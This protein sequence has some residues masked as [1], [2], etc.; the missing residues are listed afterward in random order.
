V[1]GVTT[2]PRVIRFPSANVSLPRSYQS[3]TLSYFPLFTHF[4]TLQN[5]RFSYGP[6]PDSWC[7]LGLVRLYVANFFSSPPFWTL[8]LNSCLLIRLPL[9][10]CLNKH[11][12]TRDLQEFDLTGPLPAA[13][14]NLSTLTDLYAF[15]LSLSNLF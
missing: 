4:S 2:A 6:I 5:Q 3:P 11:S 8:I 1:S 9:C 14:G 12:E 7:N 10:N 15:S 13:F